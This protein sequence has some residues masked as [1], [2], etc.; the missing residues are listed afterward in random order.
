MS[1]DDSA[2]IW[3]LDITPDGKTLVTGGNDKCVKFWNFKVEQDVIPGTNTTV[4]QLKFV[5]TQTLD[6]NE[7]VLCVKISLMLNIWQFHY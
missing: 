7:D 1:D 5:H 6:L 2:A 3:S 4:S